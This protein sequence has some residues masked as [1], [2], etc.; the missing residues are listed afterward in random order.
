MEREGVWK[1]TKLSRHN[2]KSVLIPNAGDAHL[3]PLA[4]S[5]APSVWSELALCW[6]VPRHVSSLLSTG[7]PHARTGETAALN[8]ARCLSTAMIILV[9]SALWMMGFLLNPLDIFSPTA[10]VGQYSFQV[11]IC[12]F[13]YERLARH[14]SCWRSAQSPRPVRPRPPRFPWFS[15]HHELDWLTLQYLLSPVVCV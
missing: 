3:P 2:I 11:L 7:T 4:S 5:S 9:H 14:L 13:I 12:V 8:G 6:S 1:S 15:S 10:A